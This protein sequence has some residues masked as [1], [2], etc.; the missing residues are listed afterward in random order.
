MNTKI[1][2][3]IRK[4]TKHT[5]VLYLRERPKFLPP[6]IWRLCALAIFNNNGLKLVGAFYGV[7]ETIEING[8]KY[9][10]KK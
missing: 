4:N 2:K 10:V 3:K 7:G 8:K 6:F 9:K 1:A 5:F